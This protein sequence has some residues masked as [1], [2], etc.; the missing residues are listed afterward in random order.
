[1]SVRAA[2]AVMWADSREHDPG[3]NLHAKHFP[4]TGLRIAQQISEFHDPALPRPVFPAGTAKSAQ[5]T[6]IITW[7]VCF[8]VGN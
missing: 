4:I 8:N 5:T 7:A 6:G 1:M 2:M 3:Q